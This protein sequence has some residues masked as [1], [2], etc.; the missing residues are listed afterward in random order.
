MGRWGE[1]SYMQ[2][3]EPRLF[4]LY[5]PYKNQDDLPVFDTGDYDFN[6]WTLF[7]E[8][9]FS[10]PDR[11][12]DA[13]Q[14][15][16]ALTSRILDPSS[17]RQLISASLGSLLYFSNRNVTLPGD[18]VETDR[19]SDIIGEVT[20]ALSRHWNAD[21]ELH[22]DPYDSSTER[23]DYR[24]QYRRGP[25]QLVNLS[26]RQQRD[27]LEQT[28][29][30]FLWPLAPEWHLVGR[31]YYSLRENE[32]IEALGGIGYESCCWALQLLAQSYI[33]N[34]EGD[35]NN[36]VFMQLELKGL[37]KL[38]TMVDDAL[39]RGIFGYQAGY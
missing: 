31:W 11:M 30:S 8:N 6:Y 7:R 26:Y 36:T 32:T 13:N 33:N 27:V 17:G 15:A 37:G 1:S 3:L 28:D 20:M 19:S 9:R 18:P 10:G 21:A 5:V 16:M 14:L 12:G 38:G 25:R 23:N 2:T 39:E 22:W 29:I 4:Y 35:R 34:T 24:L